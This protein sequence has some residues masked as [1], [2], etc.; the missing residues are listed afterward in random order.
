MTGTTPNAEQRSGTLGDEGT[1]SRHPS[2]FEDHSEYQT[3]LKAC[4]NFVSDYRRGRI[5]KAGAYGAIQSEIARVLTNEDGKA[6]AAFGSFI[7]SIESYDTE[8]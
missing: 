2:P 8:V 5:S 6:E 7:A 4:D 1:T 3:V